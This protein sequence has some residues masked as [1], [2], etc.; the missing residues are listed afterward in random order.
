MHALDMLLTRGKSKSLEIKCA[1]KSVVQ[2]ENAVI[3]INCLL[4]YCNIDC[5]ICL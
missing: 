5:M 1:W 2:V 4:N 3:C